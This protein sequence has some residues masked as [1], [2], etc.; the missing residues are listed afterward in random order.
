MHATN[1]AFKF[2]EFF[3]LRAVESPI[4]SGLRSH[5]IHNRLHST[6]RHYA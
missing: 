2:E 1:N 3:C 6:W 5:Q 4:L